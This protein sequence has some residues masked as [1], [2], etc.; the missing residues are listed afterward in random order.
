MAF[1]ALSIPVNTKTRGI[2]KASISK[3]KVSPIILQQTWLT[4]HIRDAI[5]QN[6]AT[7]STLYRK[8]TTRMNFSVSRSSRPAF[9]AYNE[10]DDQ[11]PAFQ[12]IDRSEESLEEIHKTAIFIATYIK[13][14]EIFN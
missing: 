7:A 14:C 6:H 12:A 5:T 4:E 13:R 1:R 8:R 2:P 3:K 10:E 11:D 9:L